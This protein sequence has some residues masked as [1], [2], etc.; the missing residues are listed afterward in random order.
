MP[1]T[2]TA[3][4]LGPVQ[5]ARRPS[6]SSRTTNGVGGALTRADMRCRGC[7]EQERLFKQAEIDLL[8]EENRA[9][10]AGAADE[11][12]ADGGPGGLPSAA[13]PATPAAHPS[14]RVS[15]AEQSVEYLRVSDVDAYVSSDPS[16][17]VTA[18]PLRRG[19]VV[20][21]D[22]Y[23]YRTAAACPTL[24][25]PLLTVVCPLLTGDA[26]RAEDDLPG[27][28]ADDHADCAQL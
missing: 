6:R 10:E 11:P 23:M 24:L 12:T 15:E 3:R 13:T 27:L 5:F 28:G 1:I 14:L 8:R 9:A 25:C 16:R 17:L 2:D 18:A 7:D 20:I 26:R 22:Q 19:D 4:D 21:F